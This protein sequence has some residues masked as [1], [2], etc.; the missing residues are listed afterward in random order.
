M[1]Q[2]D[3][4]RKAVAEYKKQG[5][6]KEHL[7][8]V[9]FSELTD[10]QVAIVTFGIHKDLKRSMSSQDVAAALWNLKLLK[11]QVQEAEEDLVNAVMK[12]AKQRN[13]VVMP[14]KKV[15]SKKR[16]VRAKP[17]RTMKVI[18]KKPAKIVRS[19]RRKKK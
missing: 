2:K 18:K 17:I 13:V 14:S 5:K 9:T 11:D 8:E 3:E 10:E 4:I 12:E 16:S 6:P 15:L 1:V 7:V 19:V